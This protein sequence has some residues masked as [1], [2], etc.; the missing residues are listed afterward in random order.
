MLGELLECQC[1]VD[2][3]TLGM[4]IDCV[5]LLLLGNDVCYTCCGL[6]ARFQL[7]CLYQAWLLELYLAA[8]LASEWSSWHCMSTLMLSVIL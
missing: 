3:P 7:V 4:H 6:T 1:D 8:S 5:C 2:W